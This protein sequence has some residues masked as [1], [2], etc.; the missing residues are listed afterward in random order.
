[1]VSDAIAKHRAS[2]EKTDWYCVL[3]GAHQPTEDE[4]DEAAIHFDDGMKL[5]GA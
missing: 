3:W 1:M 5:K 2:F 4:R